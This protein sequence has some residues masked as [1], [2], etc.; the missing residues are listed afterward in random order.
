LGSLSP[1]LPCGR[2]GGKVEREV[3]GEERNGDLARLLSS[4][5]KVMKIALVILIQPGNGKE[6]EERENFV[7][8]RGEKLRILYYMY[9]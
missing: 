2:R 9:F 4:L 8:G 3:K 5:S 6:G 1:I 7:G